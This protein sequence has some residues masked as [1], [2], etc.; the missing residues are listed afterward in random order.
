[1]FASPVSGAHV[2]P[3]VTLAMLL[4]GKV[5]FGL[6][7]LYWLAQF[8]GAFC[9]A[10][11]CFL[12]QGSVASPKVTNLDYYWVLGDLFGEVFGTF[13]FILFILIQVDKD[14]TFTPKAQRLTNCCLI[15]LALYIGRGYTYHSGGNP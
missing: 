8:G 3:A 11:F 15:A 7:I 14:T 6:A 1:M 5:H 13:V 10:F 12:L 2:N 9:G 4:A